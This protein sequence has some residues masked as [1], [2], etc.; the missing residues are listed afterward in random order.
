MRPLDRLPRSRRT[1]NVYR[2]YQRRMSRGRV[3]LLPVL[4]ALGSLRGLVLLI[5][6]TSGIVREILDPESAQR[7]RESGV[8][9]FAVAL[10]KIHRMKAPGLLEAM[11]MRAAFDPAYVGVPTTWSDERAFAADPE[12]ERDLDFQR[13]PER[14][15]AGLRAG[16]EATRSRAVRWHALVRGLPAFT[17]PAE[18]QKPLAERA[19]T[20]AFVTDHCCSR[21]LLHAEDWWR[22][23]RR[24][25]ATRPRSTGSWPRC[26]PSSPCPCSTSVTTAS[27]C[28]ASATMPPTAK[29]R[30]WPRP[31]REEAA[32]RKLP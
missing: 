18:V 20:I 11:R 22:R 27:S 12:L 4:L 10:R 3:L 5:Q 15:R 23:C 26:A 13:V 29:T 9:P 32:V 2:L 24:C 16:A 25:G 8:A 1:L 14:E 28:S 31:Y 21:T 30:R 19:V 6:R 7:R 17:G